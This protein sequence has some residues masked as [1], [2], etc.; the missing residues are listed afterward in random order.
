MEIVLDFESRSSVDLKKCGLYVYAEG[1]DTDVLCTSVKVDD[2]PARIWVPKI[3]RHMGPTDISD[4]E[5]LMLTQNADKI[6][7][8]NSSFERVLWTHVMVGKYGFPEIDFNKWRCTAAK[9]AAFALPRSLKYACE[10]LHLEQQKSNVGFR[11][12]M[13][14]CKPDNKGKWKEN[15]GDFKILC[16]YCLQ[17]AEAEHELDTMVPD[18]SETEFDI[19]QLDQRINDKGITVDIDSIQNLIYKVEARE[20]QFMLEIQELTEGRIKSTK[21]RD[22]TLA[23]LKE[24][25]LELEDLQKDTVTEILKKSDL[26]L[27]V[28]RLLEIRQSLARSS[29]SKLDAMKRRSCKDNRVRGAFIYYGSHTG[30]WAGQGIQP[31]NYVKESYES[32]DIREVLLLGVDELERKY[33]CTFQQASRCVRG[34]LTASQ[35]LKLYAADYSAI[36]ARVLAW[37]AG[38]SSVIKDFEDGL[39]PYKIAAMPVYHRKYEDISDSQRF[40]GKTIVLA[41]GY[42]GWVGAFRNIADENVNQLSDNQISGYIGE[43]RESRYRTVDFWRGILEAALKSVKTGN[44][45]SYG[46]I[47]FGM[48][49][50]FLHCRLP[51]GRLMSYCEPT[52]DM[53][54]TKYGVEKEVITFM[55]VHPKSKKWTRLSTYGGKLTENIVQG[56]ARDILADAMLKFDL[57]DY[58]IVMHVHDEIVVEAANGDIKEVEEIM[59]SP[60]EWAK[61]CPIVSEGWVRDRYKGKKYEKA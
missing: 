13:K 54:V 34:M 23:W 39:D 18:L 37:I 17:D 20:K 48:K 43:W 60:P 52:P 28:K 10:S 50:K 22:A 57:L 58:D 41:C 6:H 11:I 19:W 56:I 3:F 14:M 55:G 12:I 45:Y 51:S 26:P 9:A 38:E 31:H 7:A 8:H 36:E 30:R 35:G 21:Q 47:K 44:T 29:V 15:K 32:N 42:Q 61:G 1:E 49:G 25:G 4:S 33:G 53:I 40:V 16:D 24:N 46:R 27:N 59:S 5:L 2:K